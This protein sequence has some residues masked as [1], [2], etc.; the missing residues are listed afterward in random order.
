MANLVCGGGSMFDPSIAHHWP[1]H[2]NKN[3]DLII[4]SKNYNLRGYS[5]VPWGTK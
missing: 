2:L 1:K 4:N 3:S 5:A